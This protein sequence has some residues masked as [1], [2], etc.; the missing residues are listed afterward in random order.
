[1]SPTSLR[2]SFGAFTLLAWSLRHGSQRR[3][4]T[5]GGSKFAML[6]VGP[7]RAAGQRAIRL[8]TI[9]WYQTTRTTHGRSAAAFIRL[10]SAV[11][12]M[13]ASFC[14]FWLVSL[15]ETNGLTARQLRWCGAQ[16]ML[17]R[18]HLP[19][20]QASSSSRRGGYL[21][22]EMVM[23]IHGFTDSPWRPNGA[24][25]N[26]HIAMNKP[27]NGQPPI[28]N[29]VVLVV[30]LLLHFLAIWGLCT[31]HILGLH[32]RVP[33][34]IYV[35]QRPVDYWLTEAFYMAMSIILLYSLVRRRK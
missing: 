23:T 35:A 8:A 32:H 26:S 21:C 31:G 13:S 25:G 34:D 24:S 27:R 9:S 33:G 29:T 14:V 12:S 20:R 3:S 16:R 7:C 17:A 11:P 22:R 5:N 2:R 10:A 28:L 30:A 18:S 6:C 1:M 4:S 15:M 19:T